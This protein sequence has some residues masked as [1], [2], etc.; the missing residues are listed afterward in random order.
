MGCTITPEV[1]VHETRERDRIARGPSIVLHP[2][3]FLEKALIEESTRLGV[4]VDE[5]ATFA[6][7]YYL[8]DLDG[9]RI[10]RRIPPRAQID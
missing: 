7:L 3:R 2:G 5:L 8:A 9:Q 6:V 4:T 10:A 1:N